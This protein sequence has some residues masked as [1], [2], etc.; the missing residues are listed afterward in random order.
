MSTTYQ[1]YLELSGYSINICRIYFCEEATR[2]MNFHIRARQ[3]P[4]KHRRNY[5][6]VKVKPIHCWG[7]LQVFKKNSH[8][9]DLGVLKL[10]CLGLNNFLWLLPTPWFNTLQHRNEVLQAINNKQS[11]SSYH[12]LDSIL[13]LYKSF[14]PHNSTRQVLFFSS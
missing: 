4:I 7:M 8:S 12:L 13:R 11:L 1:Q 6:T 5:L 9:S 14:S 10:T 3:I 2:K